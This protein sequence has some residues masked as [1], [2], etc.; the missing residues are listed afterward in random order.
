M[1]LLVGLVLLGASIT[2][3]ALK[4]QSEERKSVE[5]EQQR[6]KSM[7]DTNVILCSK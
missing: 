4:I 2:G 3:V 7:C 5:Q 6:W 1:I